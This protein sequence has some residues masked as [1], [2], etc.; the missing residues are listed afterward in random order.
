M[1]EFEADSRRGLVRLLGRQ[2]YLAIVAE[3][4]DGRPVN[5][6]MIRAQKKTLNNENF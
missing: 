3:A 5:H 6:P 4:L 2:Q 1:G